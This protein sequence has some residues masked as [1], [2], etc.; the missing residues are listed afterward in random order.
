MQRL[1]SATAYGAPPAPSEKL[2]GEYTLEELVLALLAF[3]RHQGCPSSS[4]A[5]VTWVVWWL[6]GG[7][8]PVLRVQRSQGREVDFHALKGLDG[9]IRG[10]A[11]RCHL[12]RKGTERLGETEK[13]EK[14]KALQEYW[15]EAGGMGSVKEA[16][17][18]YNEDPDVDGG[19]AVV[20]TSEEGLI[21]F[22]EPPT[23]RCL[24]RLCAARVIVRMDPN[25]EVWNKDPI[26]R[27]PA[28]QP[29]S[30]PALSS[31]PLLP[32][33]PG[34]LFEQLEEGMEGSSGSRSESFR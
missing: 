23:A 25:A 24:L 15:A 31:P 19:R 29:A 28:S 17:E 2:Q 30:Q 18:T 8:T 27:A 10:I 20:L 26:C 6:V 21:G 34:E 32:G 33:A 5:E 22:Q 13:G 14:L 9:A 12:F 7:G 4:T 1:I 3:L 16:E 11:E